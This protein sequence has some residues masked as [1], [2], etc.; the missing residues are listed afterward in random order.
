MD[1]FYWWR[2]QSTWDLFHKDGFCSLRHKA[3][4]WVLNNA[5]DMQAGIQ[6][7]ADF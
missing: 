2:M 6:V 1:E 5:E 4:D 7:E 3:Q